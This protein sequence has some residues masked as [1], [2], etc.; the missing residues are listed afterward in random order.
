MHSGKEEEDICIRTIFS[1][2]TKTSVLGSTPEEPEP[3][4][5]SSRKGMLTPDSSNYLTKKSGREEKTTRASNAIG[6]DT[7]AETVES[8]GTFQDK[9]KPGRT[10][11]TENPIWY[12]SGE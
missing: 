12:E 6:K 10:P 3:G 9:E 11:E 2:E 7:T 1:K 5:W 8:L 4:T